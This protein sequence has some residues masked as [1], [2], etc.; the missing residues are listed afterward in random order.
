MP[1]VRGQATEGLK[2][3]P[4]GAENALKTEAWWR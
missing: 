3:A 2:V 4:D 1:S